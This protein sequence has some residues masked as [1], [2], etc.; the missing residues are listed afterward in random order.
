MNHSPDISTKE[1]A[2]I[3]R[4]CTAEPYSFLVTDTMLASNSPLRF[5]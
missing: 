5:R 3:Y 4:E 2:N 1:F